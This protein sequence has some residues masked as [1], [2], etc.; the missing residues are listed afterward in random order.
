LKQTNP[1]RVFWNQADTWHVGRM[2]VGGLFVGVVVRW[3]VIS[4]PTL[5]VTARG[6]KQPINSASITNSTTLPKTEGASP[7]ARD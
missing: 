2:I 7:L 4:T 1:E 5:A 3:L 6:A